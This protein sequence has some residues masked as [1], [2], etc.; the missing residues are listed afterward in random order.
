MELEDVK[1]SYF[2][3]LQ[4]LIYNKLVSNVHLKHKLKIYRKVPKDSQFPLLFLG[5][6]LVFD[7]SVKDI[8]R[9]YFLHDIAIYS[10]N[11]SIE[12]ILSWGEIVKNELVGQNIKYEGVYITEV[13]FLQMELDVMSDGF[14]NKMVMKFK[15]N[16]EGDDVSSKRIANVA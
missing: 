13:S 6:M 16:V 7:R 5:K 14:T 8:T 12:D 4:R 10:Q 11:E 2:I 1:K 15:F 3:A 9:V